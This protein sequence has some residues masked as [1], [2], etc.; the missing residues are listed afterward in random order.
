MNICPC[1]DAVEGE[2]TLCRR[3]AAFHALDLE[4]NAAE[5]EVRKAYRLLV[6]VW[7]PDRFQGDEK[8]KEAAEAKLKEINSAFEF[9]TSTT[10]ERGPWRPTSRPA[11]N[12]QNSQSQ[13]ATAEAASSQPS[14]GAANPVAIPDLAPR[15]RLWPAVR[16]S[17]KTVA[18][19]FALLLC[20]YLWIAFDAPDPTGGDVARV[21]DKGKETILR[22]TEGPRSRFIR[23]ILR[24]WQRFVPSDSTTAQPETPQ[25]SQTAPEAS[26]QSV[27][28][29]SQKAI[30]A[31]PDRAPATS[32]KTLSYITVG[33]TRDEV[34][35]QQGT[36]TASSEDKLVYGNSE[37]YLKN[38][39]VVGWRIDPGSS[40]IRVKLWPSAA[41]DPSL[42]SYTVGS[43]KDEVLKVQGTPTAFTNDKFEYGKSEVIFHNNKVVS[44]K[45][46]PDSIP[47]WAK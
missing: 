29:S 11:E 13:S 7:H 36:P 30:A 20:R 46:D 18:V 32:A 27:A 47:L 19:L 8:L 31:R 21:Y 34:L 6:K 5:A 37:L 40:S 1:G 38:D 25:T 45:E 23:A 33:W 39:S 22:G 14:T 26:Q 43:S 4:A 44:W 28:S 41:V 3:C 35:A 42:A 2:G 24:D 9:L 15:P 12:R 17:L 16:F 10:D